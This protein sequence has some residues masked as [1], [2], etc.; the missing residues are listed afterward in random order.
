MHRVHEDDH[1]VRGQGIHQI[2]VEFDERALLVFI[3]MTRNDL[4]FAIRETE[5]M[6]TGESGEGIMRR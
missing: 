5:A 2:F 4:G 1:L 6:Q 3:E